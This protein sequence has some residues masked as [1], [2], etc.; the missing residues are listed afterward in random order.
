[1]PWTIGASPMI[2]AAA[3]PGQVRLIVRD[4]GPG[5]P[6]EMAARLFE[7]FFTTRASE[8]GTG[9]GLAVVRAIVTEHGGTITA[10]SND[11][12]E[13]TVSFPAYP[14]KRS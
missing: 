12:A 1:M 5:I 8:G 9:L 11:G 3:A 2:E 14:A 13:F 6:P 10:T 4:T 7:P